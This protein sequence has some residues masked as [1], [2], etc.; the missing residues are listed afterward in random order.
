[1]ELENINIQHVLEFDHTSRICKLTRV[2]LCQDE[3][4]IQK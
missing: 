1:M 3:M 4:I 2:C